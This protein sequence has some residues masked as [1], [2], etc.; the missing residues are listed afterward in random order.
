MLEAFRKVE[1]LIDGAG[2]VL[3]RESGTEPVIRIMIESKTDELCENYAERIAKVI[4][5]NG[6]LEE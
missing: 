1:K 2:R 3:L 6:H 5:E 4:I